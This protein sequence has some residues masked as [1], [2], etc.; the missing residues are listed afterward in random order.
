MRRLRGFVLILMTLLTFCT[1]EGGYTGKLVFMLCVVTCQEALMFKSV[2]CRHFLVLPL[3][4]CHEIAN[5]IHF[6]YAFRKKLRKNSS[7]AC[8]IK[9]STSLLASFSV[10]I[11]FHI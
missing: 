3:Y 1:H 7:H 11:D 4:C 10:S 9:R 8:I 6:G 5:C 2:G